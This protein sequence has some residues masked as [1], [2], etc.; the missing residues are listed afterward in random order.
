MN[1]LEYLAEDPNTKPSFDFQYTRLPV[2]TRSVSAAATHL[3]SDLT[4]C[5]D[6]GEGSRCCAFYSAVGTLFTVRSIWDGLNGFDLTL[7]T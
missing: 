2:R 5:S 6:L 7:F 1:T 3:N 4:M